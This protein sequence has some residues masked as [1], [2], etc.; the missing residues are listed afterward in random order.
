MEEMEDEHSDR[1]VDL[2]DI[3]FLYRCNE[4]DAFA[5]ELLDQI[6]LG[7]RV[8]IS[9]KVLLLFL[10]YALRMPIQDGEKKRAAHLAI[11]VAVGFRGLA[12]SLMK[13]QKRKPEEDK[14]IKTQEWTFTKPMRSS[15]NSPSFSP[16]RVF[17]FTH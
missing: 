16:F 7:V 11:G 17:S 14:V 4:G 15:P 2:H 8:A 6:R 10:S 13:D 3:L 9:S 12:F 1:Y 5:E